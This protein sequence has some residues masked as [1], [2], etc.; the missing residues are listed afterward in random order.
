LPDC[1]RAVGDPC[2]ASRII[3]HKL[4]SAISPPASAENLQENFSFRL[5]KTLRRMVSPAM[6]RSLVD[7][8]D[9]C[10]SPAVISPQASAV[11]MRDEI[12]PRPPAQRLF[13]HDLL[14]RCCECHL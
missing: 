14:L 13:G 8:G 1:R 12:A 10:R 11:A 3:N 7:P 6:R 5:N 9:R 4:H 2:G